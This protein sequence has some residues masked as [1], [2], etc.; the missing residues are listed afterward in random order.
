MTDR[1]VFSKTL[2]TVVVAATTAEIK[3]GITTNKYLAPNT[4]LAAMGFSA[5]YISGNQAVP[6]AGAITLA[7][8]LGR[9][10]VLVTVWLK[11]LTDQDGYVAGN[12]F[13]WLPVAT[14]GGNSGFSLIADSTNLVI[15]IG[16]EATLKTQNPTTGAAADSTR[17]N[18]A[19]IFEA[20]A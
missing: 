9:E 6:A 18:F 8:G 13:L 1:H 15:R 16:S 17:V 10:P 3:T 14:A 4:T 2:N 5:Y 11:C 20:W 19:A 7:H 12:K